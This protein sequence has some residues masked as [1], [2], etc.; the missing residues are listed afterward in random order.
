ML[1][2]E[3]Q[4]Y[5]DHLAIVNGGRYHDTNNPGGMAGDGYEVQFP[6]VFPGIASVGGAAAREASAAATSA[7]AAAGS[8]GTS[9]AAASAAQTAQ[10]AAETARD[11]AAAW[12]E[13]VEDTPVET[14]LYSA[15][16]WAAKAAD[17][18]GQAQ[19]AVGGIKV[20]TADTT[21]SVL[22]SK[23][24]VGSSLS[25]TVTTPGADEHLHINAVLADAAEARAGQN[26]VK[27]MTPATAAEEI[28]ELT[29]TIDVTVNTA[30]VAGRTYRLRGATP[31]TLTLPADPVE[32]AEVLL[33]CVTA[34]HVL[35]RNGSSIM[36]ID[37]DMTLD[38]LGFEM[39]IWFDG[40]TWRLF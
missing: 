6:I 32:G 11:T 7:T 28:A 17:S 16:H 30:L 38:L 26:A 35:A 23:I 27:L 20:T 29:A 39:R 31:L 2:P 40:A 36:S 33:L 10:T 21:P 15:K 25:K 13:T 4:A 37:E 18:A 8:A 14:G 3:E 1:T 22:D 5:V 19:D 9:A 24:T 34:G 12:A